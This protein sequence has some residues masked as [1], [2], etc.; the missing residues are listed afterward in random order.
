MNETIK[1]FISKIIILTV[2]LG[3]TVP[4]AL[5]LSAASQE[6]EH[7]KIVEKVTVTNVE[8]PVRVLLKGKPVGDLTKEDFILY[9]N[10]KKMRINGF[11]KINKT[12]TFKQPAPGE[13]APAVKPPS[14]TFVLVFNVSNYNQYFKKAIDHL[15]DNILLPTD[16]VLVFANDKTRHFKDIKNK[17]AI[18]T[19]LAA[20]LKEEGIKAKRR[21][22]QYINRVETY[23]NVYNFRRVINTPRRD[24]SQ[25]EIMIDFM[26]RYYMTWGEYQQT[27]LIPKV[28]RF[29]YFA[30]FL[31]NLKGPKW[32]LNFYQFEFFPRIRPGSQTW[33]KIRDLATELLNSGNPTFQAQGNQMFNLINKIN[34]ELVLNVRFPKEEVSKLFYKVDATFHSFF[35]R[36]N[37]TAFM[38]DIE[39]NDVSSE[40]EHVLK[41][42]TDITGGKSIT[43]SNLV[44]SLETVKQVEDVYYV[45]TYA[46]ANP[47]K[48]GSLKIKTTKGRKYKVLYDNNFR[49][50]YITEYFS[51]LEQK[52]KTPDIKV[53]GFSFKKKVLVFTVSEYMM[54]AIE[55]K[56]AGRIKIRIRLVG[57]DNTSLFDQAKLLTAQKKEMKISLPVFKSIKKGE[58]NFLID[59]VD[60]VTGKQDNFH[61]NVT[62]KR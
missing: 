12:L 35:I 42:I 29:Y 6:Q 33:D 3:L 60:M 54:T 7:E 44:E 62:V 13:A 48:S 39:Y 36:S 22:L 4:M 15:F 21:L 32:V 2:L 24:K 17:A 37:N 46:P 31:Q 47:N 59:A 40:L 28:D 18:K 14:R 25:A 61:Q 38:G 16:R 52:I 34:S 51:K 55:G 45:L 23:M 11:Y 43:S 57:A 53:K 27:Y 20:D 30:R 10:K 56:N 58:Y 49:E 26:K 41:S 1:P 8:V 5:S 50:D 19:Q 9:E